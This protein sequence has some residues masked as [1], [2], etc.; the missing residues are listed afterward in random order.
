MG[1]SLR[2]GSASSSAARERAARVAWLVRVAQSLAER[3]GLSLQYG[4][5]HGFGSLPTLLVT[6]P[7]LFFDDGVYDDP[8]AS[9]AWSARAVLKHQLER[10]GTARA[11]GAWERRDYRSTLAYASD[12]E[13]S[14]ALRED[15]L[16][17]AGAEWR[18][19]L[20]R[21]SSGAVALD[22]DVAY[23]FTAHRS[24]DAFYDYR[25]HAVGVSL[26]ARY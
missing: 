19:P 23:A 22:L 26:S 11:W 9:D 6:T 10:L 16:W 21:G 14:G 13:V 15:R 20:L 8:Y 3:T 24:N 5:R 25:S 1:P 12:G 17:R 7:A 4:G 18:V 2:P